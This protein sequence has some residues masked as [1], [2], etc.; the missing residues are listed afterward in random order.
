MTSLRSDSVRVITA[1]QARPLRHRILRPEQ[2]LE[3]C[4]YPGDDQADSAHFGTVQNGILV[5]IA[6]IYP[7][8]MSGNHDPFQWRLRGMATLEEVRGEGYGGALLE[9]CIRHARDRGGL[10]MWC[11]GRTGIA[12]FYGR[13]GFRIASEVFELPGI[14]PH[15][16]LE[17]EL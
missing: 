12:D 3:A 8:D 2:P 11:N 16:R 15:V 1:E 5:G 6:S 14:G 4:V 10:R 7:Q 17:R 9:V 13:F